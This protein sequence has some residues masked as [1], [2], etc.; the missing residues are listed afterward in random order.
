MGVVFILK[1]RIYVAI[2]TAI[3]KKKNPPQMLVNSPKC[4]VDTDM[5]KVCTHTD[6]TNE[7]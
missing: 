5:A 1:S 4:K 2:G 6:K 3:A 7:Q